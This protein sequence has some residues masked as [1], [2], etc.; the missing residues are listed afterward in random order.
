MLF[1]F[2]RKRL[3]YLVCFLR[4]NRLH[5]R[6]RQTLKPTWQL[7]TKGVKLSRNNRAKRQPDFFDF[8]SRNVLPSKDLNGIL[9]LIAL[10]LYLAQARRCEIDDALASGLGLGGNLSGASASVSAGGD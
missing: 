10:E 9:Q 4:K 2:A 1:E 5:L 7:S 6:G 3:L 8:I